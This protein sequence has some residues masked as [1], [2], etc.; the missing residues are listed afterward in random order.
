MTVVLGPIPLCWAWMSQA[1]SLLRFHASFSPFWDMYIFKIKKSIWRNFVVFLPS[2]PRHIYFDCFSFPLSS[3]GHDL[4]HYSDS[5]H[6]CCKPVR[7]R[8]HIQ[9][10]GS[11]L[12]STSPWLLKSAHD[13]G[14]DAWLMPWMVFSR[15][16]LAHSWATIQC[17]CG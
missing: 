6:S 12:L 16:P 15:R 1:V 8:Q 3:L 14:H 13:S 5:G 9:W 10:L 7:Q 17:Q 11:T 4:C 2:D